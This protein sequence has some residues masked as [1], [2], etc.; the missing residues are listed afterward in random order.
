MEKVKKL[1]KYRDF[2]L[3]I[4]DCF[5]IC[6]AYYLGTALITDSVL[7]FSDYY[8]GRLVTSMT[9]YMIIYEM[10]FHLTKRHKSMIRY[11]EGKDYITYIV[12]C[13]VTAVIVG[14]IEKIFHLNV[15]TTKM[16]I[17]AA[18]IIAMMIVGYRI[19]IRYL[20]ISDV[21]NK[22]IIT[23]SNE[24]KKRLL[25]IGAGNAA[26]EII[27]T[28]NTNFKEDYEIIG[29]IDDNA[30]RL[31]FS[32]SGVRII[33]NR[34]DIVRIALENKID[35]IFFSIARIDQ[36]NK[37]E[38]LNICQ[39]TKAKVRVL[40]GI[41]EIIDNKDIFSNLRDVEIEDIL[42]RDS[43]KLDNSQIASWIKGN[44]ILVTGRW[45]LNWFGTL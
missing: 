3:V 39:Q 43:V 15:A 35:L 16:N 41:R 44:T 30:K 20:L 4:L 23:K 11:E 27:K 32:V 1:S 25:I 8:S 21:V 37:K 38:I 40:P 36:E 33:G 18:I 31:N 19:V 10:I 14:L 17:L 12:L 29:I 42:G 26:H 7:S 34:N 24:T 45:W 5:S 6:F 2:I 28:I 22:G 13:L 9:F